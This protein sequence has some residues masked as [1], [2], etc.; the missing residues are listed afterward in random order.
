MGDG[1]N[2][3]ARLE[4]HRGA[5][6]RSV[7]PRTPTAKSGTS[8]KESSSIS[9]ITA[10]QEHRASRSGFIRSKVGVHRPRGRAHALPALGEKSGPPRLSIVV[11]PFVNIGGNVDQEYFVDGVTESLTTD[12]SRMPGMLVIGR[13]TAFA[14]QG[15]VWRSQA[16]RSRPEYSVC[17]R[18]KR[19]ARR[20]SH[21][22]QRPA[23][24]RRNRQSPLGGALRQAGGRSFRY[25][26]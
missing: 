24:R 26:G 16:D 4:E 5:R 17:A 25:A 21:A 11:L 10:T 23:D 3:A 7:S 2:I 22:R 19:P 20:Q 1:I 9:A 8:L 18:G 13:N 15:Q 12:L 6:R 14:L